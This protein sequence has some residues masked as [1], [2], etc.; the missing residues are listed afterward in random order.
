MVAAAGLS[1]ATVAAQPALGQ[2]QGPIRLFPELAP[3][4]PSRPRA[5]VG[6]ISPGPGVGEAPTGEFQ[7]EGLAA[8]GIDSIGLSAPGGGFEP[9]IWQ[10]SA[11][12][13]LLALLGP[14]PAVTDNPRLR[15]LTRRLLVT[16]T[17]VQ[18][19]EPGRLLEARA[20]RLL[21]MGAL[22][23]AQE[24]LEQLPPTGTDSALARL[25][26]DAALLGGNREVACRQ[27]AA[28]TPSSSAEYWGKVTT[29]CR[30]AEDDRSG[31]ELALS[32]LREAGHT[33]DRT[34]YELAGAIADDGSV[35]ASGLRDPSA[36]EVAMLRVAG[37]PVP[38]VALQ[39]ASPA[40]L[41]AAARDPELGGERR[42]ELAER[43]FLL[44]VLPAPEVAELY[45]QQPEATSAQAL[46]QVR[47]AWSPAA[48]AAAWHALQGQ[49]EM[50][51]RAELLDALWRA[52][53]GAERFLVGEVFADWYQTLPVDT[54]LLWAAPSSARALLAGDRPVPAARWFS[55]LDGEAPR[56]TQAQR[57]AAALAPLFA[58]AGFG[59][60]SAVPRMDARAIA[61]WQL[62]V[63]DADEHAERLFALLD[64]VAAGL[65]AS[66]WHGLL[67]AP[68]QREGRVPSAAVWRGLHTA[69]AE[70]RRGET[71]LFALHLLD[72]APGEAHPEA[73]VESLRALR[74]AG[75]DREARGIAV[76][77][78]IAE[79]L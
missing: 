70:Q 14:L 45:A 50:T 41:A 66:A 3:D 74:A 26:A 57:E 52:A 54:G 71:A 39:S 77:T 17:P 8:P 79:G 76:A 63:P 29:Y 16:G 19:G 1:L 73:V 46:Q 68:L 72:G 48:R 25:A 59:G 20:G 67:R 36:L 42:I 37:Q 7:V 31:A 11:G 6:P 21:A 12:D 56:N 78:A 43:A 47:D 18:A 65:P 60:S 5:P 9:A 27:A 69:S 64:G 24:L 40:A 38:A 4:A 61:A 15:E 34:F 33:E 23:E 35:E 32:L 22:D 53:R 62:A 58:L 44:G 13:V 55:L 49:Q 2:Q 51:A 30:L 75:L 28:I 10:G